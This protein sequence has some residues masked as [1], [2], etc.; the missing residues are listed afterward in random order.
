MTHNGTN[1]NSIKIRF[2]S[3]H[4]LKEYIIF[5]YGFTPLFDSIYKLMLLHKLKGKDNKGERNKLSPPNAPSA[6]DMWMTKDHPIVKPIYYLVH[7]KSILVL[8]SM[9]HFLPWNHL[10]HI[11]HHH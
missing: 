3:V 8:P 1:I 4:I 9:H 6:Q 7:Q 5:T 11:L 10:Q 2:Y